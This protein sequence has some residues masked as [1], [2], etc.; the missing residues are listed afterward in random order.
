MMHGLT[1]LKISSTCL[2]QVIV[3]HKGEIC[4]SSLYSMI[5]ILLAVRLSQDVW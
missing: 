4:T 3:H 5:H 1:N 2:E